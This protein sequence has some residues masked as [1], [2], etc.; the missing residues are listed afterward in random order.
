MRALLFFNVGG[1][2]LVFFLFWVL[3]F[4]YIGFC[5]KGF[6]GVDKKFRFCFREFNLFVYRFGIWCLINICWLNKY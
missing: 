4:F 1:G 5:S 3:V 2:G 6:G